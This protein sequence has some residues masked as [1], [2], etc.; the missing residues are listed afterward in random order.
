MRNRC[1]IQLS[2]LLCLGL[3]SSFRTSLPAAMPRKSS[4]FRLAPPTSAPSM[5]GWASNSPALLAFTLPPYRIR[6]FAADRSLYRSTSSLRR[7]A[8]TSSACSRS[9][10]FSRANRPNGLVGDDC[11]LDLLGRN[12]GERAFELAANNG[13]RLIGLALGE[14]FARRRR[15][16]PARQPV[17]PAFSCSRRHRSR[18]ECA[19][20]RCGRGSR[21]VQPTSFSIAALSSPV[22]APFAS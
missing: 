22:K 10:D 1:R 17:R 18:Q 5:F 21:S 12:A 19:A 7:S 6:T 20:A 14:Q 16:E 9:G 15:S 3:C 4:A 8:C 11:F 13:G 2:V